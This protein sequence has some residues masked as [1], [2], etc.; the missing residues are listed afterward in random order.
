MNNNHKNSHLSEVTI[1]DVAS[2]IGLSP[3]AA[4]FRPRIN[5]KPIKTSDVPVTII[6]ADETIKLQPVVLQINKKK[7]P[8]LKSYNNDQQIKILDQKD[9]PSNNLEPYYLPKPVVNPI[10]QPNNQI[11]QSPYLSPTLYPVN[12]PSMLPSHQSHI[13]PIPPPVNM[14]SM[15]Q[16]PPLSNIIHI[17]PSPQFQDTLRMELNSQ[18]AHIPVPNAGQYHR[19]PPGFYSYPISS[20]NYEQSYPRELNIPC[21]AHQCLQCHLLHHATFP[22]TQQTQYYKIPSDN[23]QIQYQP[24]VLTQYTPFHISQTNYHQEGFP[25]RY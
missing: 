9:K 12:M 18:L 8:L 15:F 23:S 5:Y 6:A 4:I 20:P 16:S 14:P 24:I 7:K 19:P 21:N 3:K 17:R 13:Q 2:Q 11:Q 10:K 22:V 1:S 25:Q